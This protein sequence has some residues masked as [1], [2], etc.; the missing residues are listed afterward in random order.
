M[1]LGPVVVAGAGDVG[2]R[3]AALR[4]ACGDDVI[5][6]RRRDADA[7]PGLRRLRADLATGEG[8]A[9]LP[10]QVRSLVFCAAPDQRDETAYRALYL[11]GL[12]RLLD[13][14]D[15][16]RVLFVSS[17]AVFGEDA[18]EWVDEETV[19]RPAAFNGRILLE[20]EQALA[21]HDA[22]VALRLSGLY[23]PGRDWMLRRARAGEPGAPRWTNRIH[24]EDAAL[25]LSHLLDL[26][27]PRPLYLGNDDLPALEHEVLAW[28]RQREALP[29]VAPAGGAMTG[30]R[31]R[32]ARLR[33]SGWQPRHPDYRSGYQGMLAPPGV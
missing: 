8:L 9:K 10:R 19:P 25:A 6:L 30:R 5:T 14:C 31:V 24:V 3:L 2:G 20:A 33:A 17:T 29:A 13:A 28:V 32:N 22:G 1:S 4:L 16:Q 18:G 15:A 27:A 21:S 26:D 11:D 23:G 7:V 12:R